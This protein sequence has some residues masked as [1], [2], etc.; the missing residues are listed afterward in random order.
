TVGAAACAFDG[1][2]DRRVWRLG[3]G[4]GHKGWGE[5]SI[6]RVAGAGGEMSPRPF[7][8]VSGR[9]WRG[10]ALG[11]VKGRSEL[12]GYVEDYMNGKIEIDPFVTHTMGLE[13]I[14][15]AFDLM[16][17]GKSIRSVILFDQ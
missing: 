9:V 8:L 6:V 14:N 12:P 5:F 13:D 3:L 2:G 11:G 1:T 7:Q 4:C 15:K 17:E 10:S 16:H